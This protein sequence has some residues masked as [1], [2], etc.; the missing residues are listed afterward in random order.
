MHSQTRSQYLPKKNVHRATTTSCCTMGCN[1]ARALAVIVAIAGCHF[2][3]ERVSPA[4]ACAYG[5]F[6]E[7]SDTVHNVLNYGLLVKIAR[8]YWLIFFSKK[9][10]KIE[11]F[12]IIFE[13]GSFFIRDGNFSGFKSLL[14]P[15]FLFCLWCWLAG[16]C[17][18]AIIYYIQLMSLPLYS[19]C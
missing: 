16:C 5:L 11:S 19:F 1:V 3:I 15:R 2:V 18:I 4:I 7:I 14:F 6:L 13:K 9:L 12:V 17:C 8:N 10:Y